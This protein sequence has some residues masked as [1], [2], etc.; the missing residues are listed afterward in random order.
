MYLNKYA[1]NIALA[2]KNQR[3]TNFEQTTLSSSLV[4]KL[5]KVHISSL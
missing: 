2:K 3:E 1:S 5:I 4:Y